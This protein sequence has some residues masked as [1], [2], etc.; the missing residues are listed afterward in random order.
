MRTEFSHFM[1]GES[2]T[3]VAEFKNY[4]KPKFR[5][6]LCNINPI[7]HQQVCL[8]FYEKEY[9]PPEPVGF[10][11]QYTCV[12][13]KRINDK[14]INNIDH[15]WICADLKKDNGEDLQPKD[16]FI[17]KGHIYSYPRKGGDMDFG[18]DAYSLPQP[19]N[20]QDRNL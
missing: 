19:Y 7:T 4:G 18:F 10:D 16:K 20:E 11:E 9:I 6:T 1:T 2:V 5:G 17:L 15:V 14:E 12:K 13:P 8:F 3:I